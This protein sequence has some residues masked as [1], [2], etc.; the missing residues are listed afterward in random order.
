MGKSKR[1]RGK[2]KGGHLMQQTPWMQPGRE[3]KEI[4]DLKAGR[5]TTT[6][7]EGEGTAGDEPGYTPTPEYLRLWEVYR[8][9][10]HANPVTHLDGGICNDSV[11]QAWWHELAVMP[12]RRYNTPSGRVGRRFVGM[13]GAELKGVQDILCNLD[14]FVVFQTVILKQAQHVTA[15]QAIRQRIEKRLDAWAE[16]KFT[17]LVEDTLKTC[18]E[19]LTV[20]RREEMAEHQAQTYHSLVVRGK[21]HMVVRWITKRETG[22]VLHPG[23]RCTKTGDRVIKV[24][25]AKHP[26]AQTPTSTSLDL[27]PD[28]PP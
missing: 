12:S 4:G 13:L 8:D 22:G 18:M 7:S 15:Y 11:W 21:L 2:A 28:R 20:A 5:H 24:L 19:Y 23:D 16:G 10:V 27:Y 14:R 25:H 17:M 26:E 1:Q 9:W 3:E 6:P